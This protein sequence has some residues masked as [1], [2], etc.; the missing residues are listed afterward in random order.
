MPCR[1]K[2]SV[3]DRACPGGRPCTLELARIQLATYA[4]RRAP[5]LLPRRQARCAGTAGD[6]TRPVN[7]AC[8][9]PAVAHSRAL[10]CAQMAAARARLVAKGVVVQVVDVRHV[11]RVLEHRPVVALELDLAIHL[12]R[13]DW[14]IRRSRH[15]G[16]HAWAA[17][18]PQ[19]PWE[20]RLPRT[21]TER[22]HAHDMHHTILKRR[23]PYRDDATAS[24]TAR[25][26]LRPKRWTNT[27]AWCPCDSCLL[28]LLHAG[29]AARARATTR[30]NCSNVPRMPD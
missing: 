16:Q 24:T 30:C 3:L 13:S 25:T 17:Q 29:T 1:P 9:T 12:P 14:S 5:T 27:Y 4:A 6:R 20:P 7:P 8:R 26:T 15:P 23:Y 10:T 11:D 2:H 18:P 22:Q 21:Y 28:R 19:A